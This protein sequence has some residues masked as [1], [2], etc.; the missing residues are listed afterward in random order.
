MIRKALGWQIV[1]F[2]IVGIA[3]NIVLYMLYCGITSIGLGYKLAMSLLYVV[4]VIQTFFFNKK[5]TFNHQGYLNV[6]LLRYIVIYG[7]CYLINLG[8]IGKQE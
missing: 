1:R 2:G 4:G 8:V 5:W 6:T 7:V 3:S